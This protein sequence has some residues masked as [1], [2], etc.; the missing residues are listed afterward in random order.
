[1][2]QSLRTAIAPSRPGNANTESTD[3][4]ASELGGFWVPAFVRGENDPEKLF[5]TSLF[6]DLHYLDIP[7]DTCIHS[8]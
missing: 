7:V 5:D 8:S 6:R 4:S 2:S 3:F 1:M